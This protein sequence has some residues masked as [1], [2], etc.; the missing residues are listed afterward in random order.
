MDTIQPNKMH[1]FVFNWFEYN[2]YN[3]VLPRKNKI[4][5]TTLYSAIQSFQKMFG[6]P[7]KNCIT[8][9]QEVDV[10]NNPINAPTM[11]NPNDFSV[12]KAENKENIEN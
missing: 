10:N 9:I 6:N 2:R 3:N 8:S 12:I 1:T 7:R 11:V 4:S 5:A